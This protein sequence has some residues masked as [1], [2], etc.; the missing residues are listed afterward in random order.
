[1][2]ELDRVV[3]SVKK[4]GRRAAPIRR[5]GT[6]RPSA[7]VGN[8]PM[9][10][11]LSGH[12]QSGTTLLLSLLDGH[13]QCLVYPDEPSFG[14]LFARKDSYKSALHMKL[15]FLC[16]TP[17]PV[18]FGEEAQLAPDL[19]RRH[20]A[21]VNPE[22]LDTTID[23]HQ[24]SAGKTL[25]GLEE[26]EFDHASFFTKY[27]EWLSGALEDMDNVDPK[28]IV[29]IAFTALRHAI[30]ETRPDMPHGP[31]LMFKQPHSSLQG[32]SLDWF[33][34][35]WPVARSSSCAATRM[36]KILERYKI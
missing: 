7:N 17:N 28:A 36:V 8:V 27:H 26:Q 25:Q 1:M 32:N 14:R 20:H 35:A 30:V 18:H 24:L 6:H 29:E 10:V 34:N 21:A 5:S 3:G 33:F 15:D 9:M 22:H 13:S 4:F 31:L 16:G 19:K 2:A 23:F 11:W 12:S